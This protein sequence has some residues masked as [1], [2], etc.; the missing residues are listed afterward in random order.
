M[1]LTCIQLQEKKNPKK[2]I[3]QHMDDPLN[4]TYV[5]MH[6]RQKKTLMLNKTW[7]L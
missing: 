1:H 5:D 4:H 2:L 6:Q 3:F 7:V